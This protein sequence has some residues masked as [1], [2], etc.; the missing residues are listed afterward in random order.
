MLSSSGTDPA[1]L[2]PR[3]SSDNSTGARGLRAWIGRCGMRGHDATVVSCPVTSGLSSWTRGFNR[4]ITHRVRVA[5]RGHR[6]QIPSDS[7]QRGFDS[8]EGIVERRG[9]LSRLAE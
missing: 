8:L 5:L 9:S 3:D 2:T 7:Q 4:L 6:V 1:R